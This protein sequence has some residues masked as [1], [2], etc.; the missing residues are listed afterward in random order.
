MNH[1]APFE[2]GRKTG[3]L[4]E[5]RDDLVQNI[6][7]AN[8]YLKVVKGSAKTEQIDD[9]PATSVVLAG[10]SPITNATEQVTVVTRALRDG[11]V[12]YALLISPERDQQALAPAFTRMVRSLEIHDVA[13]HP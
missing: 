11:H 7:R 4:A 3:S 5:A 10:P 8:P 1:Y 13:S 9:A 12:V 6:E 2:A